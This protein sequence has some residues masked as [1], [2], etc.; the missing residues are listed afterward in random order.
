[1]PAIR[2]RRVFPVKKQMLMKKLKVATDGEEMSP[3]EQIN[4]QIAEDF[5]LSTVVF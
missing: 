4:K 3:R 2:R 5:G 1:M